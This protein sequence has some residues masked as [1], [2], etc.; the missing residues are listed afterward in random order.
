MA[1]MIASAMHGG[2]RDCGGVLVNMD[3][4]FPYF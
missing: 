1:S 4:P 3:A 2:E